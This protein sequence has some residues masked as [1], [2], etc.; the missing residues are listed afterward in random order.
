MNLKVP[1][2]IA[3]PVVLVLIGFVCWVNYYNSPGQKLQRCITAEGQQWEARVQTDPQAQMIHNEGGDPP[4]T[5]FVLSC[6]ALLASALLGAGVA[7]APL[8]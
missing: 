5:A 7:S 1:I 3:I 6:A 2:G 4:I 8:A